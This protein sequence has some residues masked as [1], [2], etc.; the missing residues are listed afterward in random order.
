M[1]QLPNN[2]QFAEA[3]AELAIAPSMVEKDWH[4]TQVLAF[5][6]NLIL[7]G[8]KIVFSGGTSLSKAQGLIKRFSEDID[9]KVVTEEEAPDRA[10]LSKFKNSVIDALES[11]GFNVDRTSLTARDSNRFFSF[12]VD[13]VSNFAPVAGLRPHIQL[14]FTVSRPKLPSIEKSVD[15]FITQLKKDAPEVDK[16]SCIDPVEI[17][18]DKLS[19][20]IWRIPKQAELENPEDRSL[21]R[22]IHDL[23]I[24]EN[25]VKENDQFPELLMDALQQ[26]NERNQEISALSP[27]EKFRLLID[28]LTT[29]REKYAEEYDTFVKSVSYARDGVVP[30]Y[31]TSVKAVK[32]LIDYVISS[33]LVLTQTPYTSTP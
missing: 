7:L 22:H 19:A 25:I 17:A 9:F 30:N 11:A 20:L 14:E 18:A 15:S 24:L 16:I 21:V 28:T 31:E 6:S 13:Y 26:D 2:E 5:I 8:Y 23:A 33:Q 1:N 10:T 27:I 29:N 12:N 4:M 3:A 32:R